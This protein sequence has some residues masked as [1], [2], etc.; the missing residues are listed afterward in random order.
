MILEGEGLRWPP[1]DTR[2]LGVGTL[3]WIAL[4]AVTGGGT[5]IR[6]LL[7]GDLAGD[8]KGILKTIFPRG[9]LKLFDFFVCFVY[10]SITLRSEVNPEASKVNKDFS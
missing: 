9:C 4:V 6:G 8:R 7:R 3:K 1:R 10:I 5:V 2:G